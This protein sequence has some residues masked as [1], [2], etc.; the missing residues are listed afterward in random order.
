MRLNQFYFLLK[1]E[2]FHSISKAATALFTTQPSVS[3]AIQELEAELGFPILIRT[4]KGVHFTPEGQ[5]VLN[6]AKKIAASLDAIQQIQQMSLHNIVATITIGC[7]FQLGSLI[8][9]NLALQLKQEYPGLTINNRPQRTLTTIKAVAEQEQPM[10]IIHYNGFEQQKI[11]NELQAH[12]LQSILLAQDEFCFVA[13]PHHLLHQKQSLSL[14]DTVDYPYL[15]DSDIDNIFMKNFFDQL[16]TQGQRALQTIQIEDIGTQRRYLSQSNA[17]QLMSRGSL[18]AGNQIFSDQLLELP[19]ADFCCKTDIIC[20]TNKNHTKTPLE[21][22]LL[23]QIQQY[24]FQQLLE[25]PD[26]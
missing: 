8:I 9:S 13:S 1:I 16:T 24:P 12:Q 3:L 10:A 22:L 11:Q 6:E 26:K 17:I 4:R 19:V 25:K 5:L 18:I 15:I 23:T 7:D 2:E 14:I 20:I 21:Q